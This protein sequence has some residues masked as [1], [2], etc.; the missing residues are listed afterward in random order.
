[1]A[2]QDHFQKYLSDT[3]SNETSEAYVNNSTQKPVELKLD[4][5]LNKAPILGN[6]FI[7]RLQELD[8]IDFRMDF[9]ESNQSLSANIFAPH[10]DYDGNV[11]DSLALDVYS[12]VENFNFDFGF[13]SLTSGPLAISKTALN[14]SIVDEKLFLDF[15][16]LY[17]DEKIV[18]L[19]SEITRQD[20]TIRL[21]INP[22]ELLLN[23]KEWSVPQENEMV[24]AENHLDFSSFSISRNSQLFELS[25]TLL[26]T[27]KE[28]LGV[29][30][31]NFRLSDFLNYLNPEETLATG[32]LNGNVIVEEPF[33]S[34]GLLA[35]LQ[36][37]ELNV[38]K[39]P[40]GNLALNAKETSEDNYD[41]N[42][43][44]NGGDIDLDLTGDYQPDEEAAKLDLNLVVNELKMSAIEGFSDGELTDSKGILTGEVKVS[45]TTSEPNYKGT[46][47]FKNAGFRVAKLNAG[48]ELR[49][50][51]VEI[52]NEGFFLEK[53][54]ILDERENEFV[55]KGNILT[56]SFL[57]PE[58][59]LQFKAKDFSALNATKD[60]NE[61]FYG[62]AVFD[63][64]GKLTGNLNLP[65]LNVKLKV[66]SATDITYI[67][68]DSEL[69][70][71]ERD[72]VVVFV[73]REASDEIR[74]QERAESYTATGFALDA[75]ITIDKNAVLNVI[76]DERTGDNLQVGG[77]GDL[78]FGI[79]PNGRT[80]LT[81]RYTMQKGHFEMN[82]YNLVKRRFEIV[83]GSS[84]SWS[85]DP[86]DANLDV[87][88]IYRVETSAASLMTSGGVG[89]NNRYRQQL[90]F[91]V[92]LNVDGE[93]TQPLLTF[94][95][96]M[97]EDERG[98]VGGQ[99]YG[100]IQQ[101]NQ[102]EEE[103]NKQV[104]S[105]LVLNRFFPQSGSDGSGGGTMGIARDNLNEALSDQLNMF[106]N[107]LLGQTGIE[108]DFGID[109]Y[110]D[111]QGEGSQD[112]TQMDITARKKLF[113][114]RVIVSVGSEVDIQGS[115]QNT[116]EQNP[117]VGNVSIEYLLT[118]NG[119]FRL[120]GFRRNQFE[121][122]IDGQ[123]IVNGI[124]LTFTRDFNEYKEL[125][126]KA[127]QEELEKTQANED[128]EK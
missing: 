120:K 71:E 2:L 81:G 89:M 46:I 1:M 9:S 96:D 24:Y 70:I 27:E 67:L 99:V 117:I 62:T 72:G 95:L 3:S 91:L 37:E 125:F 127:V 108:L 73:D 28:H 16:S 116:D 13:Q 109:S 106:S 123:L 75:N 11:L 45:G 5:R 39:V 6:V 53:L 43:A 22:S 57:N 32:R 65:R 86:F 36:I 12:D 42:L 41:L 56:K 64:D 126:A 61:L 115:S 52:N 30:F 102:Q 44:L 47:Q 18:Q 100:R 20:D 112:R 105:L 78:R 40:L 21:H 54:K 48:F 88:A 34:P 92:Y 7:D 23:K 8:P 94:N 93:L 87:R 122:V 104:F 51:T 74:T 15:H 113:N 118:E 17:Q 103:L 90:P 80:T 60:D 66:G 76:I 4:A 110:T 114:D 59:D 63:V 19:N 111:Y 33:L 31:E 35:D 25:T 55:L 121:N 58:F 85:G 14:G 128:D 77:D 79:E 26:E 38:M 68:M 69:E 29:R 50:E 82:L 84:V 49:N 97:P 10:I 98:A 107:Q 83:P 124:A 119:R 101:L